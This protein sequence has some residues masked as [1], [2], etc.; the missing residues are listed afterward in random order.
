[1]VIVLAAKNLNAGNNTSYFSM[2]GFAEGLSRRGHKV[3]LIV[4]GEKPAARKIRNISKAVTGAD[5]VHIFEPSRFGRAVCK[6]ARHSGIPV[7]SGFYTVPEKFILNIGLGWLTP[8][9]HIIYLLWHFCFY[10]N[11]KHIHCLSKSVAAQL[12]TYGYKAWLHVIPIEQGFPERSMRRIEEMYLSLPGKQNRNEYAKGLLFKLFS[13]LF[14]SGFAIPLM[15]FWMRVVLGARIRGKRNLKGLRSAVTV[16]NHVHYLDSVLVA[17]ALFPRKATYPTFPKNVKS[18]LPGKIVR[19][20]GGV[21]IPEN[22]GAVKTFF[23]E[24][25]FLLLKNHI[26]H[27]FPEGLMVPYDTALRKFRKGAFHLA[28]LA[29]V[30]IV[31]MLITFEPPKGMYRLIRKKPVMTLHVG[32]PIEPVNDEFQTD[33]QLRMKVIF[34]QMNSFDFAVT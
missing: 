25:E 27:F 28:A 2:K 32:K 7:V 3:R 12:R 5:V 4:Y 17:L 30:P 33:A 22:M 13:R 34:E 31:P 18:I 1:M 6:A 15:Q 23:E 21:P 16:C 24:M 11:F 10:R 26:V 20:L 8:A 19:I 14:F 9:R 29:R